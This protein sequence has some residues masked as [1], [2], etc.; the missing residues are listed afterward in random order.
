MHLK[1]LNL[2]YLPCF[3]FSRAVTFSAA[4]AFVIDIRWAYSGKTLIGRLG[5]GRKR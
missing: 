4:K 2:G 1:G 5:E 3:K